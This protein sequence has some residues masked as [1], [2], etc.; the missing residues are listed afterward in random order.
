MS[1][2][3]LLTER[4]GHVFLMGLN[5]PDKMNAFDV[6]MFIDL[7]M[8]M[9]EL[10]D[11]PELRCGL[12]YAKGDHFTSGLDLVEWA[13][14]FDQGT[15]PLPLPK[16]ACDP[17]GLFEQSRRI[18]KP[19]VVAVQGRCFTIG[20]ELLLGMDIRVA[21]KDARFAML[22]VK[23]GIY[24]VGGATVRLP[25]EIGWGNAMKV[26]LTG[27]EISAEEAYRLGLIQE[28]TE[29][30]KQVDR[31]FEIAETV[32]KRA[33]LGVRASLLSSRRARDE[34]DKAAVARLIPDMMPIIKSDDAAEGV[35][36]FIERREAKFTGR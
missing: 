12:F 24:P 14:I 11:D 21:S 15:F 20:L 8:A 4:R 6:E 17:F 3:K 10:N 36:S 22:E 31:A 28:L 35:K 19:M 9:G 7:A 18:E 29:N 27:D 32:A 25:L 26:L 5:R 2:K 13:A 33:P 34:G 23:R 16:E 1:E 30:G